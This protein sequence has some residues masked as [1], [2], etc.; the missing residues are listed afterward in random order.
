MSRRIALLVVF[1]ALV[2]V[3]VAM[4]RDPVRDPVCPWDPTCAE[5]YEP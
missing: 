5:E 4:W 2:L 1:G 3:L